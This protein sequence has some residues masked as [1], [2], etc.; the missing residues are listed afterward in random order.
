MTKL[1]ATSIALFLALAALALGSCGDDEGSKE[2]AT[3]GADAT[4]T[5]TGTTETTTDTTETRERTG[6][7]DTGKRKRDDKGG[8]SGGGSDDSSGSGRGGKGNS[9]EKQL[10]SK[11]TYS[12]AKTVCK[13]FLPTMID[14]DIKSGKTSAEEIAKQYSAGYPGKDRKKAHDGCLAGLKARD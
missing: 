13:D 11:N 1:R 12:T 6:K 7:T 5:S 9:P 14:R 2:S 3:T 10:T 4:Q 8:S